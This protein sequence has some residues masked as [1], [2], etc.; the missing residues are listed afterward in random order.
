MLL[1]S[2]PLSETIDPVRMD[3]ALARVRSVARSV[4]HPGDLMIG[5]L[6]LRFKIAALKG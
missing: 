4:R 1:R 5:R 3:E 2:T 6:A